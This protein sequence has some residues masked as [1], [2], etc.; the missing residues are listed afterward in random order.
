MSGNAPLIIRRTFPLLA[1][2]AVA[3]CGA[4]VSG[5]YALV[6]IDGQDLPYTFELF[7]TVTVITSGALALGD[8]TYE[9]T[10]TGSDPDG[11]DESWSESG[12]YTLDESNIICFT[13]DPSSSSPPPPPPPVPGDTIPSMAPSADARPPRSEAESTTECTGRWDGDQVTITAGGGSVV[14]RR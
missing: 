11:G 7:G 5:T 8:S 13:R 9:F 4:D 10:S 6:G 2:L 12:T 14:L 1:T 3:G